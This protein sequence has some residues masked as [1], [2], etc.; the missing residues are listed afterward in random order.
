MLY[1]L[2]CIHITLHN[3]KNQKKMRKLYA[4]IW[5]EFKNMLLSDKNTQSRE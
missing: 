3:K 1:T 2:I 5:K 4:L